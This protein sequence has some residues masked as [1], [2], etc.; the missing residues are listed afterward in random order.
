MRF[1]E[2]RVRFYNHLPSPLLREARFWKQSK[3]PKTGLTENKKAPALEAFGWLYFESLRP[4][5][6]GGYAGQP[7]RPVTGYASNSVSS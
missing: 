2:K 6:A 5:P 1:P 7:S 4:T 3:E